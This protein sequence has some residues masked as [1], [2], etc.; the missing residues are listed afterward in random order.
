[1]TVQQ[2][3]FIQIDYTGTDADT[4][5]VFDTTQRAVAKEHNIL[6]PNMAYE[7]LILCVGEGHILP[8]LEKQ[9]INAEIGSTQT[10][11]LEPEEGFGKKRSDLLKL[12]PKKL[13]DKQQLRIYPGLEVSVDNQRGVIKSISGNR[14]IVDFNHPLASHTLSYTITIH[15]KITDVQAQVQTLVQQQLRAP[16][17]VTVTEQVANIEFMILLPEPIQEQLTTLITTKTAIKK[18][19]Y[20]VPEK[21]KA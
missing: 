12:M 19:T 5:T 16:V 6:N 4:N 9:L 21:K 20:S 1:M 8:G 14:V 10:I 17:S 2:G 13:F 15:K 18:V 11:R 3:D 7:P